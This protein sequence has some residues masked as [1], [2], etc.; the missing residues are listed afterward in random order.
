[1]IGKSAFIIYPYAIISSQRWERRSRASGKLQWLGIGQL[2]EVGDRRIGAGP[3]APR[4]GRRQQPL[5]A[6]RLRGL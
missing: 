6:Q 2:T 3:P 1:M 5:S 4:T